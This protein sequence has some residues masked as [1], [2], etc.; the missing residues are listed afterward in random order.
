M[1]E[2]S[3]AQI[4]LFSCGLLATQ[5]SAQTNLPYSCALDVELWFKLTRSR[6]I[7]LT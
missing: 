3:G 1:S 4:K 7:F 6:F 5:C 2:N